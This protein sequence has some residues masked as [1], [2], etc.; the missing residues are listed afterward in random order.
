[1]TSLSRRYLISMGVHRRHPSQR[2]Q[3]GL[4]GGGAAKGTL[5]GAAKDRS[6]NSRRASE[7][8]EPL[9]KCGIIRRTGAEHGY[10]FRM[11]CQ[12]AA[13]IWQRGESLKSSRP[14][15]KQR[16][17]DTQRHDSAGS[18]RTKFVR[19]DWKIHRHSRWTTQ[20]L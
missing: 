11:F 1:M 7:R 3:R 13:A 5:L 12:S 19:T 6:D 2:R 15:A 14:G 8:P 9:S 20:W 18:S 10:R 16:E 17:V 4:L